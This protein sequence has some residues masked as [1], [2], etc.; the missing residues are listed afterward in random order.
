MLLRV[1]S[2]R[3]SIAISAM[4]FGYVHIINLLN[5]MTY[6]NLIFVTGQMTWAT[7]IG[8]LYG[9]MFIKT[10]NLYANMLLHWTANG[11]SNCFM[12]LPSV[13]PEVHAVLNIV[14][15]IRL[16]STIISLLWV[17]IISKIWPLVETKVSRDIEHQEI[18]PELPIV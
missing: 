4:A 14:F 3:K 11:L 5:G 18:L 17:I 13:A 7:I 8:I 6:N 10:G 1:Y 9:Y 2:E 16:M 12:F 15:N